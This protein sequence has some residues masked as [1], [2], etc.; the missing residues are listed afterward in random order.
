MPQDTNSNSNSGSSILNLSIG[1]LS[2]LLVILLFALSTRVIFPRILTDRQ[3]TQDKLISP[4]IQVEVL[5]GCGVPGLAN[6]LTTSLRR[7]GFDVVETDNYENFNVTETF[8]ISRV[9]DK[10]NAQRI[11]TALG[12][13]KKRIILEESQDFYLDATLVVGS[14]YK[15][16]N[17]N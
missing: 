11:A 2:L 8:I 5:N 14:D 3:E 1:F 13:P 16:F 6:Q 4:I 17:L 7:L 15:T 10:E 12:L 9:G